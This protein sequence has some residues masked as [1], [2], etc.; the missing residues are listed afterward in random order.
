[1]VFKHFGR[2]IDYADACWDG[3][4]EPAGVGGEKCWGMLSCISEHAGIGAGMV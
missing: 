4:L 2:G 3:V 1:M